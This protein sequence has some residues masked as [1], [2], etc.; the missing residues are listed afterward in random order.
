[1][2]N[3]NTKIPPEAEQQTHQQTKPTNTRTKASTHRQI[4]QTAQE[5]PTIQTNKYKQQTERIEI[6]TN[7]SKNNQSKQ[8]TKATS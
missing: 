1:M 5:H 2:N 7:L 4:R 3:N 8:Y 6:I